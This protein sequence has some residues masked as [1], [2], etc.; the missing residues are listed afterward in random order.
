MQAGPSSTSPTAQMRRSRRSSLSSS[1]SSPTLSST[2][3]TDAVLYAGSLPILGRLL[4]HSRMNL[5]K[6][7]AW[8]VSNITTVNRDQI[9]IPPL[10]EVLVRVSHNGKLLH[11]CPRNNGNNTALETHYAAPQAFIKERQLKYL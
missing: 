1:P 6:E 5:V 9:Q 2:E 8:T 7:V 4:Q 10:I 3:Q 11:P